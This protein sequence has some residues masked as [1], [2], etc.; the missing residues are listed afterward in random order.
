MWLDRILNVG[1]GCIGSCI[2]STMNF[3]RKKNIGKKKLIVV[4]EERNT[5]SLDN[6]NFIFQ[7]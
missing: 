7:Q 1:I 5:G 6:L 4:L 2:S 3:E